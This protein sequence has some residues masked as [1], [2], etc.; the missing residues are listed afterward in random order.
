M[1]EVEEAVQRL[2]RW[3]TPQSKTCRKPLLEAVGSV[4]ARDVVADFSVPSFPKSAMDGYALASGDSGP[5]ISLPVVGEILAG[6]HYPKP[7]QVGAAVQVMTGGMVPEGY[8]CVIRQEDVERVGEKIV[9][10]KTMEPFENYCP[11]GEDMKAGERVLPAYTRLSSLHIGLLAS[12]GLREVEVLCPLRVGILSTGSELTEPGQPLPPASIYNSC[13]Y[14]LAAFLQSAGQ[15]MVFLDLCEDDPEKLVQR[16]EEGLAQ[17]DLLITTGGV[18]VGKADYLPQ[19]ME[20]LGAEPIFQRVNMKPGTPMLASCKDGKLILSL[21]G[22]PFAALTNFHLF[23]WPVVAQFMNCPALLPARRRGVIAQGQMKESN[24]RRFVRAY[25]EGGWVY[26]P[27]PVH[28]AS[29]ISN[30]QECNCLIDQPPGQALE[31]GLGVWI[32]SLG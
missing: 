6:Q 22:N 27:S 28:S 4:L 24:I 20:R 30:L 21:S 13:G 18:S 32:S 15:E 3:V 14:T 29:V 12:L 2:L 7:G 16:I 31:E 25:E 5:G 11:V 1:I 19:V 9:L 8:D 17:V 23:F 26:L 10:S